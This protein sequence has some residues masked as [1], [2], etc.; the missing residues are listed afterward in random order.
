MSSRMS[1]QLNVFNKTTWQAGLRQL[2]HSWWVSLPD[3]T[4]E[5]IKKIIHGYQMEFLYEKT[6]IWTIETLNFFFTFFNKRECLGT[7]ERVQNNAFLQRYN[8]QAKR[9]SLGQLGLER[10]WVMWYVISD[11]SGV[12]FF[13]PKWGRV[14]CLLLGLDHVWVRK[15]SPKT[16]NF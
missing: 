13:C 10:A 7:M 11:G 2:G 15:F 4:F 3:G 9:A 5:K 6:C 12:K 8:W 1:P 14:I 16:P